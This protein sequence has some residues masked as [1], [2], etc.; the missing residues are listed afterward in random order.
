MSE[1]NSGARALSAWQ[2]RNWT[3]RGTHPKTLVHTWSSGGATLPE[4]VISRGG[5]KKLCAVWR[6]RENLSIQNENAQLPQ[7]ASHLWRAGSANT[8]SGG[9]RRKHSL[10]QA[11]LKEISTKLGW[12]NGGKDVEGPQLPT[13]R[14]RYPCVG[15]CRTAIRGS[16]TGCCILLHSHVSLQ[17]AL[18]GDDRREQ[19][20]VP[21]S[22]TRYVHWFARGN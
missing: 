8:A 13:T 3:S 4:P 17:P 18:P 10:L 21:V 2:Q 15:L 5:G 20:P 12:G 14:V 16:T 9:Q 11:E 19:F 6:W 7:P 22:R 1:G